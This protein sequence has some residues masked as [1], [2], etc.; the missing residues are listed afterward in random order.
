MRFA[1]KG[2]SG[3]RTFIVKDRLEFWRDLTGYFGRVLSALA[4]N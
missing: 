3:R 2:Q 1:F 4:R